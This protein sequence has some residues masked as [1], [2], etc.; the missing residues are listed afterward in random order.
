MRRV[1]SLED[2]RRSPTASLFEG[3]DEIGVSVF[4]TAYGRGQGPQLHRHPYPEV[5]VVQ[6]GEAA[7]SIGGERVV[8]PAGH[9]AIVPADTAHNFRNERD[10]TL[11]VTSVHPRGRI[12]Q[13][14]L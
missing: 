5:F 9:L 14:D 3:G 2:L 7:F 11:R 10:D 4:V 6:T 8:V 1:I 12:G 13:T